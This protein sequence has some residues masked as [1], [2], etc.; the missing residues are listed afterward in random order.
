MILKYS[1]GGPLDAL[2]ADILLYS[3]QMKGLKRVQAYEVCRMLR[4]VFLNLLGKDN[5]D[6]PTQMYGESLSKED[7]EKHQKDAFLLA[8]LRCYHGILLAYFGAHVRLADSVVTAGHDYMQKAQVASPSIMFDT[9]LKGISCF[10][11]ARETGKKK[12][13]T[14]GTTLRRKIRKWLAM[15]NPNVQHYE[16]LLNAEYLA[17]KKGT[18]VAASIIKE[19]EAA[20]V[21]SARGGYRHDAALANER[22]GEFHLHVMNNPDDAAYCVRQSLQ[23]WK[24]WGA[25]A[26]VEA[27]EETYSHILIMPE[28][29]RRSTV[30]RN[31]AGDPQH[32]SSSLW[33]TG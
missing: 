15:G 10:A 31:V 20:I 23:Y 12:Y 22:L 1:I 7:L 11:A 14:M 8:S 17:L 30:P 5:K 19:Y 32:L 18:N 13:V 26:K 6:D 27:M 29:A 4:Q 28:S 2:E 9:F 3:Q 25:T 21:L 16:S 24:D 33:S